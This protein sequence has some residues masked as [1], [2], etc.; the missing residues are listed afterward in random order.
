MQLGTVKPVF[1]KYLET[2]FEAVLAEV[3]SVP[4]AYVMQR[5]PNS[6]CPVGT[7]TSLCFPFSCLLD[8]EVRDIGHC[9]PLYQSLVGQPQFWVYD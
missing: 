4:C 8:L 5:R 3:G 1:S 2:K 9:P 7:M 6:Y